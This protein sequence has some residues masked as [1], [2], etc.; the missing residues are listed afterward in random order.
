[1]ARPGISTKN[2]EK[3]PPR[4]TFW[5][6]KKLP[7]KYRKNTKNVHFGILGVFSGYFGGKFWESRISGRWVFFRYFSWKFQVGPSRGSVAGRGVLNSCLC[8]P[9]SDGI[10]R[11]CTG[12]AIDQLTTFRSPLNQP[13]ENQTLVFH[14]PCS[15]LDFLAFFAFQGI[16]CFFF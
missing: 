3:I 6:S 5:N 14:F 13:Q 15:F 4:P 1:M 11:N 8:S 16:P 9:A 2:T 7:P 12:R 10:S